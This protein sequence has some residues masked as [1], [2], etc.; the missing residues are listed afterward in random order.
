MTDKK[1][2]STMEVKYSKFEI[3]PNIQQQNQF[4]KIPLR[5]DDFLVTDIKRDSGILISFF[6]YA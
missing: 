2:S 6:N 5:M 3:M 4:P 1:T